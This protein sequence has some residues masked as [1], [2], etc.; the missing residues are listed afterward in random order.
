M[1]L[2]STPEGHVKLSEARRLMNQALDILDELGE[3]GDIGSHLDLAICR[4][5][6][7]LGHDVPGA[8][9]ANAL[10]AALEAE[11]NSSTGAGSTRFPW[12]LQPT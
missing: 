11:L 7:H 4:L 9:G 1:Q 3:P 6:N 8:S 2:F 10:R 5:E 12:Q